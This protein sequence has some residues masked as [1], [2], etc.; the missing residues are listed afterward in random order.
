MLTMLLRLIASLRARYRAWMKPFTA[1]V[2]SLSLKQA[3]KGRNR[4]AA[5]DGDD[6]DTTDYF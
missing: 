2:R 1:A 3:E 5:Q 4:D 6:C